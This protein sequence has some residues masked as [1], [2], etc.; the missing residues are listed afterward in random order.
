MDHCIL[1]LNHLS[2]HMHFITN[3]YKRFSKTNSTDLRQRVPLN[4]LTSN[5]CWLM[6]MTIYFSPTSRM[7]GVRY[8]RS[9]L[10]IYFPMKMNLFFCPL[11]IVRLKHHNPCYACVL[12][13]NVCSHCLLINSLFRFCICTVKIDLHVG[14]CDVVVSCSLI[15]CRFIGNQKLKDCRPDTSRR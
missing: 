4:N 14:S 9:I 6:N 8:K 2:N 5:V 13:Y 7:A 10:S 1:L 11:M 12:L 3:G 15:D